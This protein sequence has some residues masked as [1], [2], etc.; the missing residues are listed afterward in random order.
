MLKRVERLRSQFNKAGIDA[1]YITSKENRYYLSGFSGTAGALFISREESYLLT[2]FRYI[3]Q[4]S[5]ECPEF[6]VKEVPGAESY[7][8]TLLEILKLKGISRMGFEA[9]DLTYHK[10][11]QIKN[12]FTGIRLK[13]FNNF[14]G[15]LRICKDANEVGLIEEAFRIADEAFDRTLPLIRPGIS[16]REVA[17]ELE[18]QMRQLG[19]DGTAF[20]IIVASGYRAAL[21]HGV[22]STKIIR[23]GELV[24]IDM[25][26]VYKGYHSDMTRTVAV[27]KPVRKQE[28]VYGIVLQAQ[29]KA[30]SGIKAGVK[31]SDV[32]HY[33]REL[34]EMKGYGKYFGHGTGHGLGLS[35]HEGPRLYKTEDTILKKGMV[36]TAE[37]G[38]YLPGWGGVRIEDAVLVEENSCRILT[39]TPKE[40]LMVLL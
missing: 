40:K 18:H 36:V 5:R 13:P 4:A 16:E 31:A 26:A 35:I 22:A 30:I 27:G 9:D 29:E 25:G 20:S 8:D 2:D 38:I 7:P 24:I 14:A 11:L 15:D 12:K 21:P 10:F 6:K 39:R 23:Q 1:F 37:P 19:A 28:E 32:D 17:V 34:I 33:A 3:Q